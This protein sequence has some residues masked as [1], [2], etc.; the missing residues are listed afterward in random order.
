MGEM[1]NKTRFKSFTPELATLDVPQPNNQRTHVPNRAQLIPGF[2]QKLGFSY[3]ATW[4]S[5]EVA[6][7]IGY[8]CQIYINAVQ[9]MD[10]TAPQVEPS[11][12]IFTPQVGVFAVGF[13]RT[14]SNY[15]L[16]GPYASLDFKF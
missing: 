9:T 1:K 8:L 11:G 3:V 13:E 4:D 10:M 6:F 7:E 5:I 2:K 12:A 14:L 15:M 16:T